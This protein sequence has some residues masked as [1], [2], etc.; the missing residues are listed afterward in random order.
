[1]THQK[2]QPVTHSQFMSGSV[3]QISNIEPM[4]KEQI[5]LLDQWRP[6]TD[7]DT[8]GNVPTSDVIEYLG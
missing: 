5:E 8:E 1:M 6:R 7:L 3:C 4:K 2:A